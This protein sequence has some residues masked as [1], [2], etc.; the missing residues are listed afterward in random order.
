MTTTSATPRQSPW[1][2]SPPHALFV[3]P[4]QSLPNSWYL[5]S[6][7]ST[8]VAPDLN[9]FTSYT[10]YNGTDK[11]CVGDGKGLN[12]SNI[13][14]GSLFTTSTHLHLHNILHVLEILKPLLSISQLLTDNNVY[15]EFNLNS[16]LIKD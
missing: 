6:G 4:G 1:Y 12:I 10:P 11:L 3:Q 2:Q 5:N 7:A 13:R 9:A 8:H 15:V 16:Y 14:S